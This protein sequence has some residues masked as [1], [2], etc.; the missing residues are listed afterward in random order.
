MP[1][2]LSTEGNSE[3]NK[4]KMSVSEYLPFEYARRDICGRRLSGLFSHTACEETDACV[5]L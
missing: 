2:N 4:I 5:C 1:S 3:N